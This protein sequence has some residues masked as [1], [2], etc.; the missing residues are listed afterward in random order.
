M[1]CRV[2]FNVEYYVYMAYPVPQLEHGAEGLETLSPM[3]RITVKV[4][5]LAASHSAHLP[6]FQKKTGGIRSI[7]PKK[8]SVD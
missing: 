3:R 5:P 7:I 2:V 1:S 8:S 6:K 4:S